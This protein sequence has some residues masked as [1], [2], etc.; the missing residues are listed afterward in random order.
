MNK[1]SLKPAS[2]FEQFAKINTIPRPSKREEKMI[3]Y[4]KKW[5]EN[6][7]LETKVDEIGN[8]I[9]RK[10]ATP[11][12]ENR[13][14][15]ILQSHMDMVCDKLVDVDFDFDN[16][17]IQTYID[18]DWLKAKGTTLGADDGIGCAIELAILE[19]SDIEHGPIECVFTRDEETGLSGAE[20]MKA[21]FMTGD[22]LINL[23][24][25][26]EGEMFVSCAG[27][28]N[29]TAKFTFKR[30]EAPTGSFFMRG[31][32]KGL[33]G[34]HSGDDI[35]KKRANAIKLLGRFLYQEMKRYEG[36][37][38]AQFHSGKLHNAIPRDGQFVIAI[39]SAQKENIMADWNVFKTE[40]EDEFHVTDTQMVWSMESTEAELVIEK[41]VADNFIRAIQ[42]VD[43][44]VYAICQDPEL[45]GMVETSSNIASIHTT[46]TEIDILSSQRSNVM[47]NLNN[48]CATI[49]ATFELAGAEAYSSDGYPAW[50]MRAESKLRDTVVETYKE[51]FGK[52]PIVRGIHAGLECGLFSERYPNIDMISFGPTLRDVHTPDER[53]Y[54]P[55]VQMVWDHLLLVL[56]R[57]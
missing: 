54:I 20:G 33:T 13:K 42:A 41:A 35:N 24:S 43:N 12:Y 39:P 45:N 48:M 19:A 5:G 36:L 4:L 44:G 16:D 38:L 31:Q 18:G 8:V 6:H 29:T 47:S 7:H 55:S 37:R 53:L 56:K 28:R 22:Y 10:P 25:E 50:K 30:E 46:E 27:G 40:V 15:I 14:T 23:D 57:I 34:G 21:D 17:P 9:I 26:D 3:E 52:E 49:I 1:S 51:L 32:L 11:G 2:V